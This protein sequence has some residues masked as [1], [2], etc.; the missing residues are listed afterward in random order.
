MKNI[1]IHRLGQDNK[2]WNNINKDL[3]KDGIDTICPNLFEITKNTSKEY[4]M[5][6]I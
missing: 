4:K 5:I 3:K 1:L 6:N 2:S